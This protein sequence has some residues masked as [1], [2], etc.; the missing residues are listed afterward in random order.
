MRL[1]QT[2]K[3]HQEKAENCIKTSKRHY[4]EKWGNAGSGG[5]IT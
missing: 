1:V 3:R 5:G 2:A 4:L